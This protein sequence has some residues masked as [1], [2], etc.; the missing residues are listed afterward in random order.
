MADDGETDL[1]DNRLLEA[2]SS[3][4]RERLRPDLELV[5]LG[6]RWMLLDQDAAIEHIYFPVDAVGSLV[7]ELDAG[8]PVEVA[9]V[10]YEGM[11]G[12]PVFLNAASTSAY[13]AFIQVPGRLWRMPVDAFRRHV[14]N[15]SDFQAVLQ[16]YTQALFGQLAINVA[17]NRAHRVEERLPRSLLMTHDRV[18]RD[19][20]PL[21]QHFL[22]QM[23]GVR[24]ATVNEVARKLQRDGLITYTRGQM[25]V[26]DREALEGAAC[27]CYDRLNLEFDRLFPR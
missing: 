6:L 9:T 3:E 27:E 26:L 23:L 1:A 2:L 17:C 16:R 24:R 15:G 25:T 10:G 13:K 20:F 8:R 11:V 19:Q 18:H 4:T 12:L 14:A 21:T 5:E 22:A 7:S